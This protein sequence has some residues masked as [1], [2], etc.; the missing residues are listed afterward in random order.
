MIPPLE[1]PVTNDD[2]APRGGVGIKWND[3]GKALDSLVGCEM[4]NEKPV[5]WHG[6]HR[7][8]SVSKVRAE[9]RSLSSLLGRWGCQREV[10]HED[11]CAESAKWKT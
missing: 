10:W 5:E 3:P 9:L 6:K 4:P 7:P 2:P 11:E 8:R 1:D